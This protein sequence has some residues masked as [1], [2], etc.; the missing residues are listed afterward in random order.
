M[1]R[2]LF[3]DD[4]Q[5]ILDGLRLSLRGKRKVWDMAFAPG[6]HEALEDLARAPADVVV[7]DMRMPRMD[8][9]EL[10][11]RVAKNCPRAARIVLSGHMDENA[12]M[13]AA[14]VAHRYLTK[15]CPSET[16]EGTLVRTLELQALL[17]DE[18]IRTSLGG[19]V[20]LP[21]SP[22]LYQALNNLLANGKASLEAIAAV[23]EQDMSMSAKVL[24]LVNTAFFALPRKISSVAQAVSYL[25]FGTLKSL[26]LA[27]SMF[28]EVSSKNG[29]A[30]ERAQ[31]NA[32]ATGRIAQ[33][34][35]RDE[36]NRQVAFTAGLLH[37]IGALA[38]SIQ[39]PEAEV[40]IRQRVE[41]GEVS[42][43]E[44]ERQQ[45]G[46]THP[47]IGAYLLGLWDLPHDI[48][49]AVAGHH[50]DF[51][52][53]DTLGIT[54]AVA[55]ASALSAELESGR[56]DPKGPSPELLNKLGISEVVASIRSEFSRGLPE[57]D[58]N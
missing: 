39:L 28:C 44:A 8:G 18:R 51:S 15:P 21:A 33:R 56:P 46:V 31:R 47:E 17:R 9:A 11:M 57:G 20:T 55:I 23:M 40:A 54:S 27:H 48:I 5:R 38:I 22:K 42:L 58:T 34:L 3:V 25:G 2:I 13:R 19:A 12:A 10:L 4:E 52:Q 24:Q 26:V 6:G 43:L 45:L 1:P 16:I 37:H 49:E 32:L 41:S 50:A 53:L 30:I 14:G 36:A 35:L 7:S 29:D